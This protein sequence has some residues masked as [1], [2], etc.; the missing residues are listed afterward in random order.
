MGMRKEPIAKRREERGAWIWK[1]IGQ[2]KR[3]EG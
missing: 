2:V 3:T 1:G